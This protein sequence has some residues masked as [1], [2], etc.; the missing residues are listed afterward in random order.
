MEREGAK[1]EPGSFQWLP[2]AGSDEMA[3]T[4]A[5]EAPCGHQ[6]FQPPPFQDSL[7]PGADN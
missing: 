6:P 7:I 2:V 1:M 4:E 3:Q 5:Q